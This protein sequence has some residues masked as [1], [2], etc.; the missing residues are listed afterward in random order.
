MQNRLEQSDRSFTG[1]I[2]RNALFS[3]RQEHCIDLRKVVQVLVVRCLGLESSPQLSMPACL[4][5]LLNQLTGRQV[6]CPSRITNIITNGAGNLD[7][8][9]I[10]HAQL[11]RNLDTHQLTVSK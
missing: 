3:I 1:L 8:G 9:H 11:S 2:L 6:C 7:N 10:G 4:K 5:H